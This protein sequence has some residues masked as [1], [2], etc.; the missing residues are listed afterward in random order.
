MPARHDSVTEQ[1]SETLYLAIEHF[2][3][4]HPARGAHL[5]Q[6]G[7]APHGP[8]ERLVRDAIAWQVEEEL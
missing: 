8:C 5:K 6:N 7:D 3:D 4:L 1:S 2:M